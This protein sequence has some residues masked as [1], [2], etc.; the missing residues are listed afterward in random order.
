[1]THYLGSQGP[2]S[3]HKVRDHMTPLHLSMF[4]IS[5]SKNRIL[6]TPTCTHLQEF[7]HAISSL[8]SVLK[9]HRSSCHFTYFELNPD[10]FSPFL[11]LH[12]DVGS[13]Q[14]NCLSKSHPNLQYML[15]PGMISKFWTCSF[16][17]K[18]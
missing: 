15:N 2:P 7:L 6:S 11:T 3:L 12:P 4:L 13:L 1:M 10:L 17:G 8:P 16:C 9:I 5:E 18:N 14:I